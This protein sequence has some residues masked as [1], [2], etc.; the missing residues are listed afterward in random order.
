MANQGDQGINIDPVDPQDLA[1]VDP[2]IDSFPAEQRA[3]RRGAFN[4]ILRH[5]NEQGIHI[6]EPVTIDRLRIALRAAVELGHYADAVEHWNTAWGGNVPDDMRIDAGGIMDD[7]QS[8]VGHDQEQQ[9]QAIVEESGLIQ[10][11]L[12]QLNARNPQPRFPMQEIAYYG[13]GFLRLEQVRDVRDNIGDSMFPGQSAVAK[14][15]LTRM[16]ER[17]LAV[18]LAHSGTS[19]YMDPTGFSVTLSLRDDHRRF[20]CS[21][22][23]TWLQNGGTDD[24][25]VS[26]LRR[27]ARTCLAQDAFHVLR[28]SRITT[29]FV[30]KYGLNRSAKA[31]AFDF[32]DGIPDG[33]LTPAE[34]AGRARLRRVAISRADGDKDIDGE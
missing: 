1:V 33:L 32:S 11:A 26:W 27:Y 15:V 10:L 12:R 17:H 3:D 7:D 2:T 30:A 29:P 34:H 22:L 13:V 31:I 23:I 19:R 4:V 24:D 9:E 6:P 5:A 25:D 28:R 8:E 20:S 14:R 16:F 18:K 21:E